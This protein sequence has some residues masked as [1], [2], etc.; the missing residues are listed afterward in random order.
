LILGLTSF[1]ALHDYFGERPFLFA[2]K[3]AF[4]PFSSMIF[5]ISHYFCNLYGCKELKAIN[6][7]H[8]RTYNENKI[9]D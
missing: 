7:F 1:L 6:N 5:V 4:L 3:L 2:A 9:K 8:K